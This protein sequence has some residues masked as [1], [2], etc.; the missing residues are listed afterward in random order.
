MLTFYL[1]FY[2]N[3]FGNNNYLFIYLSLCLHKMNK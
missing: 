3:I 1:V 2:F